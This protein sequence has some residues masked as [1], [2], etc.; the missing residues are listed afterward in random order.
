M[1][2]G[3]EDASMSMKFPDESQTANQ[4]DNKDKE[5]VKIEVGKQNYMRMLLKIR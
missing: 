4:E 2:H 3:E 1:S 5:Q